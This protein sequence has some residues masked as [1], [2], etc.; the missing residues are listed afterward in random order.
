MILF[1][2]LLKPIVWFFAFWSGT[3]APLN[4]MLLRAGGITLLLTLVDKL[5]VAN[6]LAFPAIA[7]TLV[8][9][10]AMSFTLLPLAWKLKNTALSVVL[11]IM[12]MLGALFGVNFTM[13]F[14]R[15]LLPFM[16]K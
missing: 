3:K 2:M 9:Y 1:V 8:L 11:N 6:N 14:I 4:A 5:S 16:N 12:G 7:L 15:G 10:A 13:D